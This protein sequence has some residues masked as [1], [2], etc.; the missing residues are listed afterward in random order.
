MTDKLPKLR[1]NSQLNKKDDV[2]KKFLKICHLN[3]KSLLTQTDCGPRLDHL[4]NFACKDHSYDITAL[5]ETHLSD[6][7]D[8]SEINFEGYQIFRKHRNRRGGGILI[9]A[10][11]DLCATFL[12]EVDLPDIESLFISIK[13]ISCNCIIGTCY[14]PPGQSSDE[15][16]KFINFLKMQL[17]LIHDLNR[18][19]FVMLGDL[20]DRCTKWESSHSDSELGLKLVNLL[21]NHNLF[22]MINNPTR[23]EYLGCNNN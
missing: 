21:K 6:S 7:I 13:T 14:R 18:R 19:L 11:D 5:T 16:D 17:D 10:R 4:Y 1:L 12:S 3:I 2:A 15:V 8:S 22:Q 23:R 20:N 9:Y